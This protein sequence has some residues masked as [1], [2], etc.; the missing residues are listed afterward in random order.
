MIRVLLAEDH[1]VL[2]EGLRRALESA[3]CAVVGEAGDGEAAVD[4][5][6]RLRPD[7]VVMDVSLP[8]RDGIGAT[9]RIR[10]QVTS[11]AMPPAHRPVRSTMRLRR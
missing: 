3:N 6:V 8:G 4:L 1:T 7:V 2:R 9:H 11:I 10:G 5:A